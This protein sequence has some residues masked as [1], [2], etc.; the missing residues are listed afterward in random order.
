MISGYQPIRCYRL[1][2]LMAVGF[3][4]L[5]F[6]SPCWA[7][8]VY[9]GVGGSPHFRSGTKDNPVP[10]VKTG[11]C[12]AESG[13]T[14]E[15]RGGIYSEE[16]I[17]DKR[18]TLVASGG[19]ATIVGSA[20]KRLKLLTYN[21]HLFGN[22]PF[23]PTFMD[24][25]RVVEIANNISAEDAD[26][27]ALQEVWDGALAETIYQ[28]IVKKRGDVYNKF[29]SGEKN[30]STDYLGT[31]LML[32]SKYPINVFMGHY[33]HEASVGWEC[34][35]CLG[36]CTVGTF[37]IGLPACLL[38][39]GVVC[40]DEFKNNSDA[41]ASKGFIYTFIDVDG[42]P[43][44]VLN[45]HLDASGK[46]LEQVGELGFLI[47]ALRESNP[48]Y[49]LIVMGDFN[50]PRDP[51]LHLPKTEGISPNMPIFL[52]YYTILAALNVS[53]AFLTG[54][55][56]DGCSD[57]TDV[58]DNQLKKIF[59]PDNEV[60]QTIDYVFYRNGIGF[61]MVPISASVEKYPASSPISDGEQL[62]KDLSDHYGVVV[63]FSLTQ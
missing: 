46:A 14:I 38:G 42:F 62:S 59:Y 13:D 48:I 6:S 21:T 22:T 12:R 63:E 29:W 52:P 56:G 18:V 49:G 58:P 27:V 4:L 19:T 5:S 24:Y 17:I 34:G 25:V 2:I 16:L 45:T 3:L 39:C 43:L 47:S 35:L 50:I 41:F 32:L 23:A 37:G 15:I 53:D 7:G 10:S 28:E 26:I 61:N 9:V 54:C 51:F 60:A 1:R 30:E 20:G 57:F 40:R 55:C 11:I 8:T 36:G 44:Y 31:G 33:E